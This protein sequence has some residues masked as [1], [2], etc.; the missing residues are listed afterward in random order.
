MAETTHPRATTR[1]TPGGPRKDAQPERVVLPPVPAWAPRAARLLGWFFAGAGVMRLL[2]VPFDVALFEGWGLTGGFRAA[3]G[4]AE[5]AVGVLTLHPRTRPVGAIGIGVVMV[6]AGTVHV[7]LGHLLAV[8]MV[9]NGSIAAAAFA[10]AW[11][12]RAEVVRTAT[13]R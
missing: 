12:L 7:V 4:M 1:P 13:P 9:V 2:P 11:A 6:S 8:A 5:L 10:T 3:V